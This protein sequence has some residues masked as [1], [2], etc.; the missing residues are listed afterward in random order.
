MNHVFIYLLL[1]VF[2]STV[3]GTILNHCMVNVT[4]D[5]GSGSSKAAFAGYTVLSIFRFSINLPVKT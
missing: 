3:N 4:K 1:Y 5:G 2:Y